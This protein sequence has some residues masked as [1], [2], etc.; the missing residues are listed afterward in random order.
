[1]ALGTRTVTDPGN[2]FSTAN[3]WYVVPTNGVYMVTTKLRFADTLGSTLTS[4]GY[5]QGADTSNADSPSFQWFVTAN[6][7]ASSA[8]RNGSLNS[9][10]SHFNAGDQIREFTYVDGSTLTNNA[11]S[12]TI[13]LIYKDN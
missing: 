13:M 3:N 5:G 4:V 7:S 1:F 10:V 12:M 11:A 6:A 8:N 9:R 2:N